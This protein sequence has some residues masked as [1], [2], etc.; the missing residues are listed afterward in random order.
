MLWEHLWLNCEI[1]LKYTNKTLNSKTTFSVAVGETFNALEFRKEKSGDLPMPGSSFVCDRGL[2]P[3]YALIPVTSLPQQGAGEQICNN[4]SKE[5]T[6]TLGFPNKNDL[7]CENNN[8][9]PDTVR[10][11]EGLTVTI[12]L[13]GLGI[14]IC[15]QEKTAG[16][17]KSSLLLV[18]SQ[19]PCVPTPPSNA[20][21]SFLLCLGPKKF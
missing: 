13:H 5:V 9:S 21:P 17:P 2:V 4:L 16:H 10:L 11:A 12:L 3:C 18:L 6:V 14:M 7:G 1:Y 8:K 15:L 20:V 19:N